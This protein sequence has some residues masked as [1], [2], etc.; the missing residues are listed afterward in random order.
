MAT[1]SRVPDSAYRRRNQVAEGPQSTLAETSNVINERVLDKIRM[2]NMPENLSLTA[3]VSATDAPK[4]ESR[5]EH[6]SS[7]VL[8]DTRDNVDPEQVDRSIIINKYAAEE[9]LK[10]DAKT[11]SHNFKAPSRDGKKKRI[12]LYKG[13]KDARK[14]AAVLPPIIT[15]E[16]FPLVLTAGIPQARSPVQLE[17]LI[18]QAKSPAKKLL[19]SLRPMNTGTPKSDGPATTIMRLLSPR[20]LSSWSP[21]SHKTLSPLSSPSGILWD[22]D[23]I[24]L[25][26]VNP[27]TV[28]RS[29]KYPWKLNNKDQNAKSTEAMS[30][31]DDR[32]REKRHLQWLRE[33]TTL[34]R[35]STHSLEKA[36]DI[37]TNC[38]L[39][40]AS[41]GSQM[42]V[43]EKTAYSRAS[44]A[45]EA[46]LNDAYDLFGHEKT[47]RRKESKSTAPVIW[48][49]APMAKLTEKKA[50]LR[51]GTSRSRSLERAIRSP[52]MASSKSVSGQSLE[53][54][55]GPKR[56]LRE[57][58]RQH[59]ARTTEKKT[60]KKRSKHLFSADNSKSISPP[61]LH[62]D[63]N[64]L[65]DSSDDA[66]R[67]KQ[68]NNLTPAAD[69]QNISMK[70][71]AEPS[72]QGKIQQRED[73]SKR[74]STE[75]GTK[76]ANADKKAVV[77]ADIE[78][79]VS[80][81]FSLLSSDSG[82]D[83]GS[84]LG[85]SLFS[86][87]SVTALKKRVC[88]RMK[89]TTEEEQ[90]N[91]PAYNDRDHEE[92]NSKIELRHKLKKRII[93]LFSKR[94]NRQSTE[95][96][97]KTDDTRS[98]SAVKNMKRSAKAIPPKPKVKKG[99]NLAVVIPK[100][101]TIQGPLLTTTNASTRTQMALT[102][103]T[104]ETMSII[105]RPV[106]TFESPGGTVL[107]AGD[108]IL[109][110]LCGVG[111]DSRCRL[112]GE[113]CATD[114]L[115]WNDGKENPTDNDILADL[116]ATEEVKK[117]M[118][119]KLDSHNVL[120]SDSP[121]EPV[122]KRNALRH[123]HKPPLPRPPVTMDRPRPVFKLP[124]LKKANAA[125]H[126]GSSSARLVLT[127]SSV[128]AGRSDAVETM[129]KH[130]IGPKELLSSLLP[131][132]KGSSGTGSTPKRI[133]EGT[134][135][136]VR[137]TLG[138]LSGVSVAMLPSQ[139]IPK[140]RNALVVGYAKVE[141]SSSVATHCSKIAVSQPLLLP[142]SKGTT[143]LPPIVWSGHAA[144]DKTLGR[145]YFSVVLESAH[146]KDSEERVF[147]AETVCLAVGVKRGDDLV[148]LGLIS[149]T[150]DGTEFSGK[151]V[152]FNVLPEIRGS[153]GGRSM[154]KPLRK[155]GDNGSA[156]GDHRYFL[157]RDAKLS[158]RIDVRS[159]IVGE[160]G[161]RA[162]DDATGDDDSFVHSLLN[163][164]GSM[165]DKSS[166]HVDSVEVI[167][168]KM[169]STIIASPV[170]LRDPKVQHYVDYEVAAPFETAVGNG[171]N[172]T[173]S[174]DVKA[175]LKVRK[176]WRPMQLHK[177][178]HPKENFVH[179]KSSLAY[180]QTVQTLN[181]SQRIRLS[182][183]SALRA[184][185]ES[186]S[187]SIRSEK[188]FTFSNDDLL[189]NSEALDSASAPS[190]M[191]SRR[192]DTL[193]DKAYEWFYRRAQFLGFINDQGS[194]DDEKLRSWSFSTKDNEHMHPSDISESIATEDISDKNRRRR[195]GHGSS[196]SSAGSES[197]SKQ[198]IDD[199]KKILEL[200]KRLGMKPDELVDR[201][202]KGDR[203]VARRL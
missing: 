70:T 177:P 18:D 101:S 170:A 120:S 106:R 33:V 60:E 75:E 8:D 29:P 138:Y 166:R 66:W 67:S 155:L 73:E 121:E 140:D 83:K 43:K 160:S 119:L 71:I 142:C 150:I 30:K 157:Q 143:H 37:A 116:S 105:A 85:S 164:P 56:R 44:I 117:S 171:S 109:A 10:T 182:D 185:L 6:G 187:E 108:G 42:N 11:L 14:K 23:D 78:D 82:D 141:Y 194:S 62:H 38:S 26:K 103:G 94:K 3:V 41:K 7:R 53:N 5:N 35:Q 107:G 50:S 57:S 186:Q 39:T 139:Q 180:N 81:V 92:S 167:P 58:Y 198:T 12:E 115:A 151:R 74:P 27:V 152:D 153:S 91:T 45:V 184:V 19:G 36:D 59:S 54:A 64:T 21:R 28:Q 173:A 169:G 174:V 110:V 80:S 104:L 2:R 158:A 188:A 61:H 131:V 51:L 163:L 175:L 63:K 111:T 127:S 172:R 114:N 123:P 193:G 190:S 154:F 133:L 146:L 86:F 68:L 161:P 79:T 183:R 15:Q 24:P 20:Y 201:I 136:H 88:G 137:V 122:R 191:L 199:F 77:D 135:F 49:Q 1:A 40:K 189:N 181:G 46:A 203:K 165:A 72:S 200:A 124:V 112:L 34:S 159:D 4:Q 93:A 197:R 144:Y 134:A 55:R 17:L 176:P 89:A 90:K 100:K 97:S 95:R 130:P 32:E 128:T 178:N 145:L 22:D 16:E 195:R 13:V 25:S 96:N 132:R 196:L 99:S 156:C 168:H 129:I 76:D 192:K 125:R 147:T 118:D 179:T 113:L 47:G 148:P 87:L 48:E 98:A 149:F 69:S 202:E 9:N 84:S 52:K 126:A 102:P 65:V 162:W 31:V